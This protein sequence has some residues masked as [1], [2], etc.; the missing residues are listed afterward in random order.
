MNIQNEETNA[1]PLISVITPTYN[2]ERFI[3][4]TIE[5]VKLQTYL[6]WELIIVDDC[7]QDK[8]VELIKKNI[9]RKLE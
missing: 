3:I 8:T 5:S 9:R 1:I 2:A 4:E 7:S 6:N